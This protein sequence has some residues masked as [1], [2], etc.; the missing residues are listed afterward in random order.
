MNNIE[1]ITKFINSESLPNLDSIISGMIGENK[2]LKDF[3]LTPYQ[4]SNLPYNLTVS[5]Y[6]L[7]V[8]AQN[9]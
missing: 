3:Q 1:I 2:I 8:T 5:T 9:I 4:Y 6:F 7:V